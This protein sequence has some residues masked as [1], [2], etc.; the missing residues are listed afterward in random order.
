[1]K[2]QGHWLAK[3]V[4]MIVEKK[5]QNANCR[6]QIAKCRGQRTVCQF[7]ICNLQ[8]AICNPS[9]RRGLNLTEVLIAM[10]I[11]TLGL[12]GVA[13]IF[14]V[15][16]FYM[17]KAEI[18]DR[19]SAI[20]QAVMNDITARGMLNP[21]AWY[22]M[23]PN[24]LSNDPKDPNFRFPFL[25]GKYTPVP[26]PPTSTF[27]RPFAETLNEGI[28]QITGVPNLP[29]PVATILTKQFG[30]AYI[31][32]PMHV[33]ATALPSTLSNFNRVCYAFPASAW[34]S[35]A[36]NGGPYYSH[37]GWDPWK[38]ANPTKLTWP[39]RRVTLQQ[40][41]GWQL[42]ARV[43][44]HYFRGSDDLVTD[45]PDRDD[46]PASQ[47]WEVLVANN[48]THP[49]ARQWT[50]D[51]SWIV[52]VVPTT[53]A[54]RN[55]MAQNPESFS[56]D[57]SVVVFYK[58]SLPAVPPATGTDSDVISSFERS[59]GAK[60]VSTGLTGGELLLTD[61]RDIP[62]ESAFTNLKAG[63]W[64][65]LCGPHPN[66][67][68]TEPRFVLNWYQVISIDSERT[69]GIL[70]D[71]AIERLVTVRGPQWP[72]QPSPNGVTDYGHLSNDLCVGICRG[73]VAVHTKTLRLD[74]SRTS[75]GMA[76]ITPPGVPGPTVVGK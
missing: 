15:G 65:M 47:N 48:V 13:A 24:P 42:D 22:V 68:T 37:T 63:Q 62:G 50:G 55:G 4:T 3:D 51:Y 38:A 9:R 31:L 16:G 10:G 52:C 45:F 26:P 54:A 46:R 1:M 33:A 8:F 44:E 7:T 18:S 12:L 39:I 27:T 70:N 49:M 5:L 41:H 21:W 36:R 53:Y 57:V 14:P 30:S 69:S 56:Y 67:T 35:F 71:P 43:A 23:T 58:R 32:D 6:M 28:R 75:G 76:I 61:L 59:V 20:A 73:A 11:L 34:K 72:W 64:I 25:D 74:T 19:G 17:Q 60:I 2:H 40:T 29:Q 66:S